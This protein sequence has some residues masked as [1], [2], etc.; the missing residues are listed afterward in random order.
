[1]STELTAVFNT[2]KGPI[3]LKLFADKAPLTA[4]SPTLP[5]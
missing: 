3:R 5:T 1:M 2:E 4:P